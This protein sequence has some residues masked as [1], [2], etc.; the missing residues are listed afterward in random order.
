MGHAHYNTI[1]GTVH[2]IALQ[3]RYIM[4]TFCK[5]NHNTDYS[6]TVLYGSLLYMK[7]NNKK[8]EK[9]MISTIYYI[10]QKYITIK[11]RKIN[12]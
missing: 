8:G 9:V 2:F 4:V 10:V 12:H 11:F 6:R 7:S 5:V 1:Q 3:V